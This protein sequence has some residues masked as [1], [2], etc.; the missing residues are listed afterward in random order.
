M[1]AFQRPNPFPYYTLLFGYE[2]MGSMTFDADVFRN[3]LEKVILNLSKLK[4]F[5]NH[6]SAKVE[7]LKWLLSRPSYPQDFSNFF[8][9][10]LRL[11]H[12]SRNFDQPFCDSVVI[13]SLLMAMKLTLPKSDPL[14]EV[15][16]TRF[17]NN[18]MA[19][20]NGPVSVQGDL[21]VEI[22]SILLT[23]DLLV[24]G[25]MSDWDESSTVV[26]LGNLSANNLSSSGEVVVAGDLKIDNILHLH[27]N[28]HS[29]RVEGDIYCRHLISNNHSIKVGR[30]II[31]ER[32]FDTT[33][34]A[35]LEFMK[36]QLGIAGIEEVNGELVFQSDDYHA[37]YFE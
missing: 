27:R 13:Y 11:P 14:L 23:G 12:Y 24:L 18:E 29:L 15:G 17:Q 32:I 9:E 28:D 25:N 36:S 35:D 3:S 10:I 21:F 6:R 34:T 33:N 1:I 37:T 20:R 8:D 19:L 4:T 16:K 31:A 7:K 26:V 30:S 2:I 5:K 22:G